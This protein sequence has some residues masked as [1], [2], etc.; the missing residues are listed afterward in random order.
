MVGLCSG[1]W[2]L[3]LGVMGDCCIRFELLIDRSD[4]MGGGICCDGVK[5]L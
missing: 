5:R 4:T 1:G 2:I 3:K